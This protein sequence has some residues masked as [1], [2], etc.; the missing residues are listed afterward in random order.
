MLL[1]AFPLW[2]PRDPHL[3]EKKGVV[4]A[5]TK[6]RVSSHDVN[7]SLLVGEVTSEPVSRELSNGDVVS[8]FDVVTDTAHGRVTVPIAVDGDAA[9]VNV[10]DRVF[11]SGVTRRR[12]FR[13]G[14][15]VLSRTE[16][17][18]NAVLPMRRK[19]QVQRALIE[20]IADLKEAAST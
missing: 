4:M 12:F 9:G 19:T 13:S 6:Q 5:K 1:N 20:A 2:G 15:G 10:G 18:A 17:L 11:V 7:V 8:S 14:N 16:V 3:F